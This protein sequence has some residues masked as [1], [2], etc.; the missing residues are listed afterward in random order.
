MGLLSV[1]VG[2]Q[3]RKKY[4][5]MRQ[6]TQYSWDYLQEETTL[7][8]GG[9]LGV[10][11]FKE[12]RP[13]PTGERWPF[14]P[15]PWVHAFGWGLQTPS[16]VP[17]LP[18]IPRGFLLSA[19]LILMISDR[20][21]NSWAQHRRLRQERCLRVPEDPSWVPCRPWLHFD[22]IKWTHLFGCF[23]WAHTRQCQRTEET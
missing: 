13:N 10:G 14:K 5:F 8:G 15:T 11:H 18:P 16:G 1:V 21:K 6:E 23:K 17:V 2:Q 20:H 4:D 3:E 9:L 19:L 12:L 22:G 7:R